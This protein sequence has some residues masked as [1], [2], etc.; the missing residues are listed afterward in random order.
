MASRG[1]ADTGC[2]PARRPTRLCSYVPAGGRP[3]RTMVSSASTP[4]GATCEIII[5]VRTVCPVHLNPVGGSFRR[6]CIARTNGTCRHK[7]D[8]T[9]TGTVTSTATVTDTPTA[10]ATATETGTAT[11][12]GTATQT[13]TAT[14]TATQT[15][16]ATPTGLPNGAGCATPSLC[17]SGFC[18]GGVCCNAPC[19]GPGQSCNEPGNVGECVGP[20]PAP[21]A[22]PWGLTVLVVALLGLAAVRFRRARR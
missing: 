21:A 22:S 7:T 9:E 11:H 16:T 3:G 19:T 20:S 2:G 1:Y 15:P 10:T 12:T 14:G 18:P 13:A 4:R 6:N 17:E 8:R 5:T